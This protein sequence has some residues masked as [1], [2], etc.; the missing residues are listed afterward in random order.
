MKKIL[1]FLLIPTLIFSLTG[2]LDKKD[3]SYEELTLK[4]LNDT[5]SNKND[6]FTF[7]SYQYDL[8]PG[9][10]DCC[11]FKS[12]KYNETITVYF[13]KENNNY[14]FRDNYFQLY[15]KEDAEKYFYDIS[16][17]Y[18]TIETKVRFS[19]PYLSNASS[20]FDEYINNGECNI[21][22]YFIS[23]NKF[24]DENINSILNNI[25]NDK[26]YGCF[27]FIVTD[28][29]NLLSNYTLDAILNNQSEMFVSNDKYYINSNFQINKE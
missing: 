13:S 4:Y 11:Y 8:F 14:S 29:Q 17:Q 3:E 12:E 23:N 2:C 5:Y 19:S 22:V 26:I 25:I 20:S 21:D 7:I 1:L 16:K 18:Q 28:D 6:T 24:T 10:H 9:S 27:N 15:M